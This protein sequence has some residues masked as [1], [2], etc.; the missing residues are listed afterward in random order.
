MTTQCVGP[1]F[2]VLP[3]GTLV[4][5]LAGTPSTAAYPATGNGVRVDPL[6]GLWAPAEHNCIQIAVSREDRPGGTTVPT[7]N[8]KRSGLLTKTITNPSATRPMMCLITVLASLEHKIA[9]ATESNAGYTGWALQLGVDIDVATDTPVR[10][11]DIITRR[12]HG[13]GHEASLIHQAVDTLHI[14]IPPA[15]SANLRAQ[16]ALR[17]FEYGYGKYV[18]TYLAIRGIGV[19][20]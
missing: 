5:R 17:V 1:E 14:L 6:K 3:D 2:D 15:S 11:S 13:V 8:L 16:C 9:E 12:D 10:L 4:A 19:T 18:G 7:G 20:Q